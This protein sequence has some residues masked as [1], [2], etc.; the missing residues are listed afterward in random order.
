MVSVVVSFHRLHLLLESWNWW[1]FVRS[2]SVFVVVVVV[3]VAVI[4]MI[5]EKKKKEKHHV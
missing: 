4:D 1:L 2:F 3:V 5:I